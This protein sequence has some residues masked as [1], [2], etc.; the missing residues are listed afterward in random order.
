MPTLNSGKHI[1]KSL[2][3][4]RAQ[5]FKDIELIVVDSGSIDETL[6][7]LRSYTSNDLPIR[8]LDAP[9]CVPAMAR[10]FGIECSVGDYV[11]FCDSDD[12]MK[13]E[14]LSVMY[15]TA[16]KRNA[17]VTVCDFDM[18]YPERIVECFAHMSDGVFRPS[19]SGI[20]DYYY[21]FGAAPKPNN[22]VWA[23]LY[24]REFLERSDARFP[25]TRYS[26][27]NLFNLSLLFRE[28]II[29]HLVR[30]LYDYVQHDG[31]AMR[32]HVRKTN[33]GHLFLDAFHNAVRFLGSEEKS[34]IEP[35]LSIYAY[36]R[37]K[38]ILFY[39][40]LANSTITETTDAVAVFAADDTVIRYLKM[41]LDK[42]YIGHY[43]RLHM[44]SAE[45]EQKVRAILLACIGKGEIPDI[46]EVF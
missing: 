5:T 43:C 11:A 31:S 34:L 37:V 9:D 42:D 36:T 18:I 4:L 27:D 19:G 28:P 10:N 7:I 38:S 45:W 2:D 16:E 29:A 22:Y 44:Y 39:A 14:M 32:T 24:R 8:I 33:H 46:S 3:S 23:R 20:T 26:E 40:R 1:R 12:V 13:P 17:D 25:D 41:C 21:K 30:A 35:I 6:R 15:N